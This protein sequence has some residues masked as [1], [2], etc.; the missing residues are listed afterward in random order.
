MLAKL[1]LSR[2]ARCYM[3]GFQGLTHRTCARFQVIAIALIA[4]LY[5]GD[6]E[7]GPRSDPCFRAE[8]TRSLLQAI[9]DL[10]ELLKVKTTGDGV[11]LFEQ[12]L[13]KHDGGCSVSFELRPDLN[14]ADYRFV[15]CQ[16]A[17][18]LTW[19]ELSKESKPLVL[20]AIIE[21]VHQGDFEVDIVSPI[22]SEALRDPVPMIRS[23]AIRIFAME[24]S[25]E[26]ARQI[27]K[28]L[29][30]N[31]E[32]VRRN[33]LDALK[34][35]ES[36]HAIPP[37][38][39]Q[40]DSPDH[41]RR[42]YAMQ[43]LVKLDAR[44]SASKIEEL[45]DD[46]DA[47]NR[48]WAIW[49]L[50]HFDD[51]KICGRLRTLVEQG[52]EDESFT[53]FALAACAKWGESW[54]IPMIVERLKKYPDVRMGPVLIEYQVTSLV[55]SIIRVLDDPT[56][57]GGDIGSNANIRGELM[58]LLAKLDPVKAVP[59]LRE[60]ARNSKGFLAMRAAEVL[61][62]LRAEEAVPELLAMLD[63][64]ENGWAALRAL[65]KIARPDTVAAILPRIRDKRSE[66]TCWEVLNLIAYGTDNRVYKK[67]NEPCKFAFP[68]QS[69][70]ER[71]GAVNQQCGVRISLSN[72]IPAEL[73]S[74]PVG[75][76]K[77]GTS[78]RYLDYLFIGILNY[79]APSRFALYPEQ[80][81]V[82]IG[83]IEEA[84]A[85]WDRRASPP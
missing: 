28:C 51:R 82:R 15:L 62:N 16:L 13:V 1:N 29:D 10:M 34:E 14:R 37:L 60:H 78:M 61:G 73:L 18:E 79:H 50:Y 3:I 64:R 5:G 27:A 33:A 6:A 40:L 83:T 54:P 53:V 12:L 17:N 48:Y 8:P 52:K 71:V 72:E 66:T 85:F 35:L 84:L 63:E 19:K 30:D 55:P 81:G 38:I 67:L 32:S 46:P 4:T 36:P 76:W 41:L 31:D 58:T 74:R 9:P 7:A 2:R 22:A 20:G 56:M 39:E 69:L 75:E 25:E 80:G 49:A 77:D 23:M 24:K 57:L 47:N 68:K 59:V 45:I 70:K 65:A 26:S 11:R 44:A 43:E 42:F 21:I